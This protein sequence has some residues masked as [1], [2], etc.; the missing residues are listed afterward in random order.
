M[1]DRAPHEFAAGRVRIEGFAPPAAAGPPLR[2]WAT[3]GPQTVSWPVICNGERFVVESDIDAGPGPVELR[4]GAGPTWRPVDA[5]DG[6]DD[7]QLGVALTG[8]AI[9]ESDTVESDTVVT[10][11]HT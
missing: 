9:V 2:L 4:V 3:A 1:P 6:R 5:G 11:P 10:A 8:I 7:R